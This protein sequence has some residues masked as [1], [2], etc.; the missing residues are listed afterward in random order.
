MAKEEDKDEITIKQVRQEEAQ[1][2]GEYRTHGG[3]L[4]F[5]AWQEK[6][7]SNQIEDKETS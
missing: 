4:D 2:W 6:C 5:T 7:E 3:K 1:A